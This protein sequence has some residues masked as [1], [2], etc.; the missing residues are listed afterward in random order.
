M[1][2]FLMPD[3][4]SIQS[5]LGQYSLNQQVEIEST[6]VARNHLTCHFRT[7]SP[8]SGRYLL[9]AVTTGARDRLNYSALL[10]Q[11][12]V[13]QGLPV[14]PC[15]SN[16][17]GSFISNYGDQP[18]LLFQLPEGGTPEH[19]NFNVCQQIGTFLGKMHTNSREF[20]PEYCNPRSLV[21]LSFA[22][23]E[24]SPILSTGEESLLDEQLSRFKRTVEA[25]PNLPT[26]P[27]IGSLFADQLIF[28]NGQ[29]AAVTG[30]YFSCSDW[31]LLDVAQTVNEWCC[32]PHGELDKQLCQGLLNAYSAERP[33]TATEGQY[34]QDI[35]C[36]SATRFWVS[37]LLTS[38]STEGDSLAL[39]SDPEEYHQKLQRRLMSY[40]PLPV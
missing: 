39:K 15:V 7:S 25:A 8:R 9:V 14:A 28:A 35:L 10:V 26:G 30:F 11:H 21:W 33:F 5:F 20:E 17:Q 38:L 34:W 2:S 27:L 32:N 3:I 6:Y 13:T 1:S 40:Y 29:L 16:Q 31:W 37:R 23:Q 22:A 24:L 36:F 19:Q 18:A 4:I 12:L